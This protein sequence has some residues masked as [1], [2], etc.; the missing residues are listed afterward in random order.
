MF[1]LLLNPNWAAEGQL[2][3]VRQSFSFTDFIPIATIT[4]TSHTQVTQFCFVFF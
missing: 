2:A 1:D 3:Q 4:N